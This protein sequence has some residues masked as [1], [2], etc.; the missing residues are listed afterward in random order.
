MALPLPQRAGLSLALALALLASAPLAAAAA[1]WWSPAPRGLSRLSAVASSAAGSTLAI[2]QGSAEVYSWQP[3]RLRSLRLPS[4]SSDPGRAV[5]VAAAGGLGVAAFSTGMVLEVHLASRRSAWLP[6]VSGGV[7]SLA[8]GGG[9]VPD[10][11]LATRRGLLFARLG[12][13]PSMVA[14]GEAT[15]VQAPPAQGRSW[16][17]L[18]GGRVWRQKGGAWAPFPGAPFLGL[19]ARALAQLAD[20]VVLVGARSGMVWRQLGGRWR[21]AFQV[22]PYGG[23]GGV[24]ELT[25]MVAVGS[26]AAYLGTDGFGTLLTPDGG[27]TWYS[28]APTAEVRGL[29]AVGPVEAREARGLVLALAGDGAVYTHRLQALPGPP[30]YPP[31]DQLAQLLGTGAVVLVAALLTV[32]GLSLLVRRGGTGRLSSGEG[33]SLSGTGGEV[34]R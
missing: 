10:L 4:T 9:A 28:A 3:A 29:A 20:G 22:L 32:V 21:P 1:T 5:A 12:S 33:G 14:P 27:Y 6:R 11:A 23:L 7:Q 8:L 34:V 15:A 16:L 25:S 19:G 2:R 30:T 31:S 26:S 24:P 18:V 13:V 17:A